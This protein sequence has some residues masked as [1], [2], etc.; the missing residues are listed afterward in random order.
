MAE[1]SVYDKK[2]FERIQTGARHSA[3]AIV[4]I[5]LEL[6]Q[7]ASVIDVGCGTGEFLRV[8]QDYGV[9]EILGIDGDY[10][11]RNLL[12]IPQE[13]FKPLDISELFMLERT[14]DLALCLEV[15]EHLA[16]ERACDFIESLTRLAPA[17]LFSAAIPAQDG[18][19]HVNEQWPEY[20][21]HLFGLRGFV[22]VDAL[23]KRIWNN[24]QI[25]VW[26][27]QNAL[28]FCTEQVLT[29]HSTLEAEFRATNMSM[30]SIVHPKLYEKEC[31]TISMKALRYIR[32]I[33][34]D[35]RKLLQK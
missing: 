22:P 31:N 15:A 30:L 8:F 27:R 21:A 18:D 9:S 25:E 33:R 24:P 5:V 14:Y 10:V 23:R 6:L 34:N 17:I 1:S 4:P 12:A 11:D 26:Y 7:P 19:H 3:M 32:H 29:S 2:F 13:N 28:L 35:T 16:P 20:W